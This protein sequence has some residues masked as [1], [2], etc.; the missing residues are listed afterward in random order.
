MYRYGLN[1]SLRLGDAY[2]YMFVYLN[3]SLK[4]KLNLASAYCKKKIGTGF[5]DFI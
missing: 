3:R 2:T 5:N 4:N 1:K